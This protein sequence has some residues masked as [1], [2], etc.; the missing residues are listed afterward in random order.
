[1]KKIKSNDNINNNNDDQFSLPLLVFLLINT[2]YLFFIILI[3]HYQDE[4][5]E[6]IQKEKI[7][8]ELKILE[9]ENEAKV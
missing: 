9:Q 3:I 8:L 6:I 7:L 1:M 5:N 2:A 4:V